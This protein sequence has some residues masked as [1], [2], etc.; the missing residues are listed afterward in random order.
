MGGGGG[1]G[2]FASGPIYEKWGGSPLQVRYT[3][4]AVHFRSGGGGGGGNSL[5]VSY[6]D[7]YVRNDDHRLQYDITYRGSGNKVVRNGS[8]ATEC[9][10]M[11]E[12]IQHWSGLGVAIKFFYIDSCHTS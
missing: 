7:P 10:G 8:S 2:Q 9:S 3:K 1:G 6:P 4:S 11:A 12:A 5:L